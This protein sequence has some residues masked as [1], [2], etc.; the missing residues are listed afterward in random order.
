MRGASILSNS[1]PVIVKAKALVQFDRRHVAFNATCFGFDRT[2]NMGVRIRLVAAQAILDMIGG[3]HVTN[4]PMGIVTGRALQLAVGIEVATASQHPDGLEPH[5][6]IGIFSDLFLGDASWQSMTIATQ[7][8][9]R[10]GVP[11]VTTDRERGRL[12]LGASESNM[13]AARAVA[14]LAIDAGNQIVDSLADDLRAGRVA[15]DAALQGRASG[16]IPKIFERALRR[17]LGMPGR[18]VNAPTWVTAHTMFNPFG[19]TVHAGGERQKRLRMQPG[20]EH[21]R[22]RVG[23]V[24]KSSG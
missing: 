22:Q 24:S 12:G 4:R 18:Q 16:C 13:L 5:Q 15:V 10:L 6:Q 21:I 8:N 9:F 3:I 14:L 2:G 11:G 20:S 17:H 23:F 19:L 7:L 1:N